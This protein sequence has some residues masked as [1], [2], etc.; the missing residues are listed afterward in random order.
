MLRDKI[1]RVPTVMESHGKP[2]LMEKAWKSHG[3]L[4]VMEKVI[5]FLRSWKKSLNS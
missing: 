4:E 5:E 2:E 1:N 3:I